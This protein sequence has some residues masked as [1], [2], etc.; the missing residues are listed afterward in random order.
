MP[1]PVQPGSPVQPTRPKRS[2]TAHPFDRELEPYLHYLAAERRLAKNTLGS[3]QADLAAFFL[4]LYSKRIK[5][6]TS[7]RTEHLRGWLTYCHQQGITS[8]SN[9]RRVSALRGFFKFLVGQG[10]LTANPTDHLD[11]PKPG[12]PL[13]K[14]L[15]EAEVGQLLAAPAGSDPLALRNHAMLH[16]LYASGLR[17]SELVNL[18][19]AAVNLTGGHLRIFGKGSKERL[20]PFGEQARERLEAYLRD[21]R[22]PLLKKR[23]SV[24]LFVTAR[25]QAMTRL[26]YWQII[27][28]TVFTAGIEKK[29]S[30]HTLRHSFATHLLAHGADLRSV[31]MMLGHAD[32]TTTQIYTHVDGERL[33]KIHRR[34]HPRG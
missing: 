20:V 30:P 32:I 12:R 26:R 11:L 7:V 8:R 1:K 27:Q 22:P 14:V 29:V 23:R 16:L 5:T 9:A 34:F 21:G 15:S 31:Q 13:P 17:V 18:P 4:Y 6:L 25:G 33:K 24:A 28:E 2:A 3:Y 10:Q 19:L